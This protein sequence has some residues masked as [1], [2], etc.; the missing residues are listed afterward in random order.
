MREHFGKLPDGTA[1]DLIT[2]RGDGLEVAAMT[3]GAAIVSLRTPD[4]V[5][6]MAD[7]ALGF[8]TLSAYVDQRAYIGAV[9][10]RYANRI[11]GASFEI[12]GVSYALAANEGRNQ[13]HGGPAGF[14]ERL[15]AAET[16]RVAG[17]EGVLFSRLSPQGEEGY[18][19]T[20]R[21]SV[22][23]LVRGRT[24]EIEYAAATDAPTHVNL[25]Q[26][27]YFDLSAGVSPH[28]LDHVLKIRAARFTPTDAE[29]IPT[30]ELA[31]VDETP[32]DF[33]SQIRIGAR[34][35]APHEQLAIGH[36]YDHNWVLDD[37]T[38]PAVQVVDPR[39]RRT[40]EM[41]TTEP[42]V[43]FYSGNLLDGTLV[44]IGGRRYVRHSGFCLE[45]QHF[46][47]SPHHPHFPSTRLDPGEVYRSRTTLTFGVD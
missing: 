22:H 21:V 4:R 31:S 13:L 6:R 32:F 37:A 10:G 44:G 8:D 45:P 19:G 47:D 24:L 30:G 36:G 11:R 18:P 14:D 12:D 41:R 7:I 38:L 27:T 29:Q 1:V 3:Y 26:H 15:W 23:Y 25:T 46:P 40:L 39:S 5:G 16:I 17:T 35:N 9:V 28:V 20:L 33:R 34:I 42:G 43:Q 2:L